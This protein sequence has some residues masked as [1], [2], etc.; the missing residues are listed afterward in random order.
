MPALQARFTIRLLIHTQT[1]VE[2][3]TV[4]CLTFSYSFVQDVF[5]VSVGNLPPKT[6]VVIKIVYMAELTVDGDKIVF[7]LPGSV[8]P[9]KKDAALS[10]VTQTDVKTVK[11]DKEMKG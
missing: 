5:T 10:E 11:V 7:G 1:K 4:H 9:W 8:A 6:T 2:Y 3:P